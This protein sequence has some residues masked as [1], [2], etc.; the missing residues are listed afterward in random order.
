MDLL[1]ALRTRLRD[2]NRHIF[3]PVIAENKQQWDQKVNKLAI[4]YPAV[5]TEGLERAR[6][7]VRAEAEDSRGCDQPTPAA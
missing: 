5:N 4:K 2:R 3:A 1:E 6:A 7:M